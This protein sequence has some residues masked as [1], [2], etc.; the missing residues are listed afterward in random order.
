MARWTTHKCNNCDY[1]FV[2]SGKP[3]ALFKVIH[4]QWYALNAM[5]STIGLYTHQL[6]KN[7]MKSVNSVVVKNTQSGTT[8]QISVRNVKMG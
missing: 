8:N 7:L 2:G 5:K 3:D 4:S 1:S 6:E